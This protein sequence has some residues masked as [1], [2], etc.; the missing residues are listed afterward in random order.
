MTVKEFLEKKRDGELI[1][2]ISPGDLE[3]IDTIP[4]IG[5]IQ[6]FHGKYHVKLRKKLATGTYWLIDSANFNSLLEAEIY[7]GLA[8][9]F[10]CEKPR[11]GVAI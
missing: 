8:G 7:L 6:K 3:D 11:K 1:E 2:G 10:A 5:T 9:Y 4:T